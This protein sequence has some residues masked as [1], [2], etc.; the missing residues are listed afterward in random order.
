M[1]KSTGEA[2]GNEGRT[3]CCYH[4]GGYYQRGE[5]IILWFSKSVK[6]F[7]IEKSIQ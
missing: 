7:E 5:E 4:K 6:L 2:E 3:V 1:G